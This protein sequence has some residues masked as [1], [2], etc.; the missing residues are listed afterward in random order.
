[1]RILSHWKGGTWQDIVLNLRDSATEDQKLPD[2]ISSDTSTS[3]NSSFNHK[4]G[5]L[6][7][8]PR[9]E[10]LTK[11]HLQRLWRCELALQVTWLSCQ[12]K[13]SISC[14]PFVSV[15]SSL[16]PTFGFSTKSPS[17]GFTCHSARHF[18]WIHPIFDHTFSLSVTSW[19]Y[20]LSVRVLECAQKPKMYKQ[21]L[22]RSSDPCY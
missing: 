10:Q 3:T 5:I 2:S 9:L 12:K 7:V 22:P 14:S 19:C 20:L 13:P 16:V 6:L 17:S 21:I 15:I 4:V 8:L 1:M 11:F 18:T